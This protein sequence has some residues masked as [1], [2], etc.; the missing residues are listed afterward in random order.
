MLKLMGQLGNR[1][2]PGHARTA[3]EGVQIALQGRQRRQTVGRTQPTL[4]GKT[5]TFENIHGLFEKNLDDLLVEL[6]GL[7]G[8]QLIGGG[9]QLGD[10]AAITA[11]Q[12]RGVGRQTFMQ[13]PVQ[14]LD[15]LRLRSDFLPCSQLVE[16]AN[17][18]FM[19]VIGR[20]K[21][22]F[23]DCQAAFFDGAVQVEQGF[24]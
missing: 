18:R 23:T 2:D 19:S 17:Q 3:L 22:T 13:Q 20:F 7:I 4:Q 14:G 11:N 16:H 21:E 6:I 24:T 10:L 15:Q 1:L 5:C 9:S 12:S 8:P